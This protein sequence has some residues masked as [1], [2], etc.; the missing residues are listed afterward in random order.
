MC[1][2][3]TSFVLSRKRFA[4]LYSI[5]DEFIESATRES[6]REAPLAE[7]PILK[8]LRAVSP[9]AKMGTE[10]IKNIGILIIKEIAF[11]EN[12]FFF[13]IPGIVCN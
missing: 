2:R 4:G 6:A 3:D 5:D 8:K 7:V 13:L 9:A 11:T 10:V 1:I 12:S